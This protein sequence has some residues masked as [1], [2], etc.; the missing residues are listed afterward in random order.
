MHREIHLYGSLHVH[1]KIKEMED[2]LIP[3][4]QI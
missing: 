3:N 4:H 1:N 2:A